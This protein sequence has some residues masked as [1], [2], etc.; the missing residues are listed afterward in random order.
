MVKTS[1]SERGVESSR[2]SIL[3]AGGAAT[4]ASL[5]GLSGSAVAQEGDGGGNQS[6][7]SAWMFND[8]ARPGAVFRVQSPE[9][10]EPPSLDAVEGDAAQ[11]LEGVSVRVVEYFNTNEEVLLFLPPDV[12]VEE[13]ELY[14]LSENLQFVDG[15]GAEGIVQVQFQTVDDQEFTFDLVD[16]NQ[17][18][19]LDEG[20]EGALRPR[21]FSPGSIFRVVS[22]QQGWVPDDVA[23]SGLFTDYNTH[24]A[25]YLGA[26]DEFLF[27][28]QEDATVEDGAI[29]TVQEEWELFN[30][31]GNLVAVEFNRVNEDSVPIEDQYL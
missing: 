22:G 14:Q 17:V 2:R 21:N 30:P 9:L 20:G 29:Y 28:P 6:G 4:L 31:A 13:G 26:D 19:V 24:H 23:Q 7:T 18:E 12:Q 10:E 16:N 3:K 1:H 8:E 25:Q 15:G 11:A 27:F 5:V